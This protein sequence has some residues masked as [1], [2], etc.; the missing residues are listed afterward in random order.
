M[1]QTNA[2]ATTPAYRWVIYSAAEAQL[3][4][5][6]GYWCKDTARWVDREHATVFPAG[7]VNLYALPMSLNQ[8][9]QWI[10]LWLADQQDEATLCEALEHF[11]KDKSLPFRSAD[12]LLFEVIDTESSKHPNAV[13]L[14]HFIEQWEAVV[15]HSA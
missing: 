9:R 14:R 8:D 1:S 7:A 11:C 4:E 15:E 10:D 12:D 13:W 5:G 2:Q 6:C 3:N